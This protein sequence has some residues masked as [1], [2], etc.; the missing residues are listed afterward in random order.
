ML[1]IRDEISN[2]DSSFT[3]FFIVLSIGWAYIFSS[4]FPAA[5]RSEAAILCGL[6]AIIMYTVWF[7][8]QQFYDHVPVLRF[9]LLY[10][11]LSALMH[12][13]SAVHGPVADGYIPV[14]YFGLFGPYAV[15]GS[16]WS[17][18]LPSVFTFYGSVTLITALLFASIFEVCY[19]LL[20]K[21]MPQTLIRFLQAIDARIDYRSMLTNDRLF[22]HSERAGVMVIAALL[23]AYFATY[24]LLLIFY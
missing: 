22:F 8:I 10:F 4:Y 6:Y 12:F 17:P 20:R 14:I 1:Q 11:S 18:F 3:V 16:G 23:L 15:S 19:N 2:I 13:M 9:I 7:L 21:I 5:F 24:S